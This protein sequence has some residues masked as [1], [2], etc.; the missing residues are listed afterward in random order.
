MIECPKEKASANIKE[1]EE[2][3]EQAT[4]LSFAYMEQILIFF[5][6]LLSINF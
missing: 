4:V 1:M 3:I 2:N 6:H 5:I